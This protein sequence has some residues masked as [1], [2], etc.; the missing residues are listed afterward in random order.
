MELIS[1]RI[2][3]IQNPSPGSGYVFEEKG[4]QLISPKHIVLFNVCSTFGPRVFHH[5]EVLVQ[6]QKRDSTGKNSRA[7]LGIVSSDGVNSQVY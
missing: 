5:E 4:T 7:P 2:T 6:P 3:S 1:H